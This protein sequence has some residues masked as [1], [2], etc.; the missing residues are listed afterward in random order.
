MQTAIS[1]ID[2]SERN[3]QG[4]PL[5]SQTGDDAVLDFQ[6]ILDSLPA[7]LRAAFGAERVERAREMDDFVAMHGYRT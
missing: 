5:R 6:A 1:T 2:T 4:C 7:G 3:A